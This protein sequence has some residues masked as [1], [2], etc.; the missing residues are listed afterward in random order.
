MASAIPLPFKPRPFFQPRCRPL[1]LHICVNQRATTR[2]SDLKAVRSK[3]SRIVKTL[4]DE[5]PGAMTFAIVFVEIP[6]MRGKVFLTYTGN[7]LEPEY[8][9]YFYAFAALRNH[10]LYRIYYSGLENRKQRT[11]RVFLRNLVR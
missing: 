11:Q 2:E 4:R 7:V 6:L 8:A 3:P 5:E 9:H 1:H 10:L